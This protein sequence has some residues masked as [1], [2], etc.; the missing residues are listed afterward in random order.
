MYLGRTNKTGPI[1]GGY[2]TWSF[3]PFS[4]AV[5][6]GANF[7]PF[8]FIAPCDLRLEHISY[9][10]T[11]L[12]G[13]PTGANDAIGFFKHATL[14]QVSG[15]TNLCSANFTYTN[16]ASLNDFA[17]A[18][19]ETAGAAGVTLSTVAGVRDIARGTRVMAAI[20]TLDGSD[21]VINNLSCVFTFATTGHCTANSGN[22]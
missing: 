12:T 13:S 7:V 2:L 14:M 22:D 20:I 19:G 9:N 21:D 1:A 15:A 3:G 10:I 16:L 17:V 8:G 11:S 18:S 6:A 4:N 5:A